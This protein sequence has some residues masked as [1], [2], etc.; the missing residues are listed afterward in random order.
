MVGVRSGNDDDRAIA[1]DF[2]RAARVNLTEEEVDKN[3]KG[4]QPG[5]V[6]EVWPEVGLDLARRRS[7]V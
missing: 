7:H 6:D 3:G 2:P 1:R 4:P 5:I